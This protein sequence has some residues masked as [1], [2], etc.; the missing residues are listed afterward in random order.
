MLV[1]GEEETVSFIDLPPNN[2][3]KLPEKGILKKPC[4]YGGDICMKEKWGTEG[5]S[6][7]DNQEILSQS[8]NN[9]GPDMMGGGAMSDV[10]NVRCV[11]NVAGLIT[12]TAEQFSLYQSQAYF[13][14]NCCTETVWE[15]ISKTQ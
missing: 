9:L 8:D 1:T 7:S 6:Q 13:T 4:P 10:I 2:L 14:M 11:L 15:D 5:D 3:S 12:S